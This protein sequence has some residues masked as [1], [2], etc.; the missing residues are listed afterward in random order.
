M[1]RHAWLGEGL[2]EGDRYHCRHLHS[3]R[4]PRPQT[5]KLGL[6]FV[7]ALTATRCV[8]VD[9]WFTLSVSQGPICKWM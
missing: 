7:L 2:C 8:T 6:G 1:L 4:A 9:K 3:G 5:K